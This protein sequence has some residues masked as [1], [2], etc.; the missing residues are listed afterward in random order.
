[1][2]RFFLLL[3]TIVVAFA[4][5]M[6]RAE[7]KPAFSL[8]GYYI[9]FMRMPV[10]GLPEWKR[11]V[12]AF[13]EDDINT[14]VLWM[15]GGF[16]SKKYPLT[17]RYNEEH[18]NVRN[19][20]V[21]E[22]ID[23]AHSKKIRVL[24]GFTPFG[25]DG[26][27]QMALE[28]PDWKAKKADGTPVD[29]FGIH[30]WGW[31]LCPSRPE[32]REFMREYLREMIFDFYPN[33]DGLMVESSD[34]NV[35]L[36][37][38]CR[39]KPYEEEFKLAKEISEEMWRANPE[40]LILVYPH[41]F[42]GLNV[43]GLEAAAVKQEFDPRWGLMFTPHS[44]HFN[45]ELIRRAKHSVFSGPEAALGTP[46]AVMEAVRSA[47]RHGVS[48]YLPSLEAFSYRVTRPE[49]GEAFFNGMRRR[50]F[51]LDPESEGRM[52]YAAP[53]VL[54]QR[55]AAR[56]FARNP[57]LSLESF[58]QFLSKEVFR[59]NATPRAAE[60]LLEFQRIWNHEAEWYWS[61]PLL[62]PAF[63]RHR[64]KR[65]NWSPEKLA[66]YRQNL[67]RLREIAANGASSGDP[68][69][70]ETARLARMI[71]ERWGAEQPDEP[72]PGR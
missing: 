20:F 57:D 46:A 71:V 2:G 53:H 10:M 3:L 25:Y 62:E 17:W 61:S 1:M 24:L 69:E 16:R 55:L 52:P 26:V 40:A 68:L 49:S 56:E 15:P 30:C 66:A 21:R 67:D 59:Q 65:F 48:G 35:C 13:S 32:A 18:L 45:G 47:R 34:Y 54:T 8:R 12:D 11:A 64:A 29:A 58:K 33:A 38:D 27:N 5:S 6:V 7:E 23:Y 22:L 9:T 51:G 63:F 60:D 70:R 41:Y 50:P 4:A 42:T 19:D 43:P 72:P 14:L 36:C 28:H 37:E 39:T 31:S 44:A